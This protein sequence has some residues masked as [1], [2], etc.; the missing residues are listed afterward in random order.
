MIKGFT[1]NKINPEH[2]KILSVSLSPDFKAETGRANIGNQISQAP[3]K[4]KVLHDFRF[5]DKLIIVSHTYKIMSLKGKHE[6]FS[7]ALTLCKL[8]RHGAELFL[9]FVSLISFSRTS[10]SSQT[11]AGLSLFLSLS[12]LAFLFDCS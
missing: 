6:I 5:K 10:G 11:Q 2:A 3:R 1:A 12:S 9:S 4:D 7:L 8:L